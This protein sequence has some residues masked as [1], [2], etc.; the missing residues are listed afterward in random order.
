MSH[1]KTQFISLLIALL[2]G[3]LPL[4]AQQVSISGIVTDKKLN[5][6]IIGASVVV[7]G[8]SN[9]CITDLDGNFQL[10]NVASG[11]TL[12]VSYIG[13][14]TQEIP[15]Q[16]GKTS[17]QVTLS[18]DTQTL[19][20]VVVVGF[21][22]Q[23]KVNL[24]GAVATVDTKALESRPVSQ[25]GQ[26]LQGTVPGLNL[27]TADLGGQLGQSMK[28]N[29]RGTGTIGTG[30][31]GEP[32]I[33][34][35][36]MEGNM[37][38][39]NPEDIESISVL[40]DAASSSIYGSRAAFGVI[41]ITTKK[42][43]AGKMT[44]NYN[45]SFRYSGPTNLPNQ[46]DSYR[47]ANFF[48][49][50]AVNQGDKII[51]DE[52]TIGR[53]QDY[54]AG[55]ITTTTIPN[56]SNW[57]FHEKANDNV[58]WYKTHFTWAWSQEHNLS[59]SGGT[60]KLQYYVSGSY[61]NQNGNL[62]YGNDNM[63]RYNLSAKI[64]TKI[65]KYI[66]FNL[67]TKFIRY[68]LD[69]PI[70]L[71]EGGLLYHDIARMWPTMP[72]KDPNGHYM[73]NGKLAQL[74]D[75]GRS[76]THNDDIYLQGQ[77]ILHPLKNWNI[78]AEA[79]M[80]VINQNKQVNLN[81]IYEYDI[82]DNPVEL[83]FSGSYAPGATF[84]R[85]NYLNSNFYTTSFY[86]DYTLEKNDHYL[87]VMLGMNTEEYIVR[88]LSAQRS[89]VISGLIPE[90]SYF[91]NEAK[92]AAQI[93]ADNYPLYNDYP[94]LF[95]S[96]SLSSMPEV[97]LWRAYDANLTP[98]VNHFVVGYLQRNGGGNSGY[99]RSMINTYLMQNGL[100]IYAAG[101][102]YKGDRT[103]QDVAEGRDPRLTYNTLMPG[104]MLTEKAAM[105]EAIIDGAGYYYRAPITEMAENRSTTGYSIKKGLNT[106]PS[107]GPTLPST[108]ACVIFRAAEA[109]LNYME[110]DYE[111]N[112]SLDAKSK[113]YW[114]A[115]RRRAGMDT[116]Y[117]KTNRNT[118]LTKEIDLARYSGNNLVDVTI[119]NIRRE[120]RVELAA[121]GFR[122][123]DLRR[124]CALDKM[125]NYQVEGFNLWAENYKRYATPDAGINGQNFDKALTVIDL[126]EAGTEGANV[127]AKSDGDYLLPYRV[128]SS[129]IAYNGYNW[130]PNRYLFPI[131]FDHFRLTTEV[132]GSGDYTSSPIYQNPGWKIETNSL[133]EGE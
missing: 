74:T 10:N 95:N 87:K 118:D 126:K 20:E 22:T 18:E 64:N 125:Q 14:Q 56:G 46:L 88:S 8:T 89:D 66:D 55:K 86:T 36:G 5:E 52:E 105:T 116:D 60:E 39:L 102:D 4:Q 45:N 7:K 34:I 114:E 37:N 113:G 31:K 115:I 57:H 101:T 21:G 53:I 97:L 130:N 9:G 104:D 79:G 108:T 28:V 72:F 117:E 77:V 122:L 96:N 1:M 16:K 133:P 98:A 93:V 54:M 49:E 62:R 63:K 123:R 82:N 48:N 13:Y 90:I 58:N 75:G 11:S 6:P 2:A 111:L 106:D 38:T 73:R 3:L 107:Q 12:V 17:Y 42:G 120:R 85:M 35:D 109:Y 71:E 44:I 119:Y 132:E 121:E 29:I 65:N 124:W 110:A 41:L 15:V 32:L 26:A 70:Y 92:K 25:V 131:A 61:L 27:S 112:H 51:F 50:A 100:P 99:T 80:R 40:K 129:N 91:L 68:D 128:I 67:S 94:A 81:K 76:K 43:K 84:A 47:F 78:Y 30:S 33:L 24:T 23:K 83:A 59:M 103:Y 19:D 127:S 69:N